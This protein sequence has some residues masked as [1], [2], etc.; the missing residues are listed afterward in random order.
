MS[1]WKR[2]MAVGCSHGDLMHPKARKQ[3]LEFKE[4]YRPDYR[5]ELGD[6][7]DTACFRSGSAGTRDEAHDPRD[8]HARAVRWIQEYEPTHIAWGNHDWRLFK[9]MDHPKAIVATLAAQMWNSLNDTAAKVKAKTVPYHRKHG[10]HY[11]GGYAWGHGYEYNINS[12]QSHTASLGMPVCMAHLHHPHQIVGR[13]VKFSPSTC[14]G[15][16]ADED[17][18]TYGHERIASLTHGHGIAFGVTN[19]E[20]THLWLAR[21]EN[22]QQMHFPPG[23]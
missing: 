1:R 10:W 19:G 9:L 18:L 22:G 16:L 14:V 12:L 13:T 23:V 5:F 7:I 11:F 6:L 2:V 17:K 20:E 21:S 8:D 4:R 3:V 15:S